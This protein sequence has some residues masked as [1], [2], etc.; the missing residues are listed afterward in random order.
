MK[1]IIMS[2]QSVA[3]TRNLNRR[4][5]EERGFLQIGGQLGPQAR[6]SLGKTQKWES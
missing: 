3:H 5:A 4:D 1:V 2:N 6:L